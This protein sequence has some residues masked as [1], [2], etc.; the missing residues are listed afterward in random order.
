MTGPRLRMKWNWS[1]WP[2]Q[3]EDAGQ[4]SA[5][6]NASSGKRVDA[7]RSVDFFRDLEGGIKVV[8]TMSGVSRNRLFAAYATAL[9]TSVKEGAPQGQQ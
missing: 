4:C 3:P 7:T 2:L 1:D 8:A 9:F 5:Q 6:S